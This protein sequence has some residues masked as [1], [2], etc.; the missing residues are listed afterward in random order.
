[1]R[2]HG[3]TDDPQPE[4]RMPPEIPEVSPDTSIDRIVV[5]LAIRLG[6]LGAI[7]WLTI[8]LLKPFAMIM[9]WVLVLTVALYPVHAWLTARLGGRGR[10]AAGIVTLIGLVI[11]L[12][13]LSML[14]ASLIG[15]IETIARGLSTGGLQVPSPP[16]WVKDIPA[17][18]A[19]VQSNWDLAS[20]NLQGF[21][22]R[23]GA[24]LLG[25]G[26]WAIRPA[27]A[28]GM[29]LLDILL[30]V[31]I[32]GLLFVPG[33]RFLPGIRR[34]VERVM[35]SHGSGF[36]QLGTATIRSVAR[37]VI[38]VAAIQALLVGV[39]LIAAGV[40]AAGLLTLAA[41]I[42][43]IM[44]IGVGI[45]VVPV[46]VWSWVALGG[47]TAMLLTAWLSR[48]CSAISCSSR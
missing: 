18:G 48:R 3:A 43:A 23:N 37:G 16:E 22:S 17:A 11:V 24:I 5:D 19:W 27:E 39:G 40:P 1:M 10:F 36:V 42:G 7:A 46:I 34:L 32:S 29:D 14:V 45:V 12:G 47:W 33:P 9:L 8:A 20:S 25:A 30:A 35:G 6:F 31:V 2:P 13:P 15:S 41:L 28:L 26:K 44:Q 4:H 21:F 38:G